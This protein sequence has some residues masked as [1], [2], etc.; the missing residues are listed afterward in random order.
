MK[1]LSRPRNK[2]DPKK[3]VLIVCEWEN[4]E[5]SYFKCFRNKYGLRNLKIIPKGIG[6]VTRSLIKEA[7]KLLLE[8]QKQ[9]WVRDGGIEVWCVFDADPKSDNP[10]QIA[11]FN[12][13]IY[14][15]TPKAGFQVAYSN[16]AFEYWL[17]LHFF[18]NHGA[19]FHRDEYKKKLNYYL[20][21]F[22]LCY[23]G[24]SKK[25]TKEIFEVLTWYDSE[26]T[27][28]RQEQA[29]KRAKKIQERWVKENPRRDTPGA[30][31][32][33]TTMHLLVE[34]LLQDT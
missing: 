31:E 17:L 29:I 32:S 12:T 16:Q 11:D 3:I 7:R 24:D 14:C 27:E 8:I 22:W 5:P 9:E 30:E 21:S 10:K 4:T 1:W 13:A 33:S 23:D 28:S 34:R 2:K 18:D 6:C 20:R 15:D 19:E 26:S 25:V